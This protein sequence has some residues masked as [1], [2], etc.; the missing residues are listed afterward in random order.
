[1]DHKSF[2]DLMRERDILTKVAVL[3]C[4][5]AMTATAK[6]DLE[7]EKSGRRHGESVQH[8]EASRT[9]S[10]ESRTGDTGRKKINVSSLA[11]AS[12][13]DFF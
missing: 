2:D 4:T 6:V 9:G 3:E 10:K 12:R 8:G 13:V 1:M 7:F 11:S 5:I